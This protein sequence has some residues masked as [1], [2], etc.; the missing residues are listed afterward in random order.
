MTCEQIDRLLSVIEDFRDIARQFVE[1]VEA[2][3]IPEVSTAESAETPESFKFGELLRFRMN[4][5]KMTATDLHRVTGLSKGSISYYL[6]NQQEPGEG[7]RK[8]IFA[9]LDCTS[10]E[11]SQMRLSKRAGRYVPIKLKKISATAL[12]KHIGRAP[13]KLMEELR[14]GK[15]EYGTARRMENGKYDY[16]ISHEVVRKKHGIEFLANPRGQENAV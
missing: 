14:S 10:E 6:S 13:I 7:N 5:K 16:D 4:E 2:E 3:P 15:S 1:S 11:F 9:A 8:K 12:A